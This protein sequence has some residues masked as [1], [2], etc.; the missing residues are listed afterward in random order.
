MCSRCCKGIDEYFEFLCWKC[1]LFFI[2][3]VSKILF[4]AVKIKDCFF[5]CFK[6]LKY[7]QLRDETEK[8][9]MH[10]VKEC[11]EKCKEQLDIAI[12]VE[13]GYL[14]TEHGDFIGPEE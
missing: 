13:L 7:P 5:F 11:E 12:K 1:T 6:I 14:N 9:L 10:H 4:F 2:L 8:I 3:Y